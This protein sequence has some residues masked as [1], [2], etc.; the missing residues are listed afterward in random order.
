MLNAPRSANT[1]SRRPQQALFSLSTAH[2]RSQR[3]SARCF[4]PTTRSPAGAAHSLA[5]TVLRAIWCRNARGIEDKP[6]ERAPQ[7]KINTP[8]SKKSSSWP[9][10]L[11]FLF[12]LLFPKRCLQL[13]IL[14]IKILVPILTRFPATEIQATFVSSSAQFSTLSSAV[15]EM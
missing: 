1:G 6:A 8:F 13:L 4:H 12:G 15:A 9:K 3:F 11:K 10:T 5:N 14:A 2:D 7:K